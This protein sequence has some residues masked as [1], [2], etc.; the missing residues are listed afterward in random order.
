MMVRNQNILLDLIYKY[1]IDIIGVGPPIQFEN[2]SNYYAT[3]NISDSRYKSLPRCIL[4]A[5]H[6]HDKY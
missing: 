4:Y 5:L 2:N 1:A 6:N 3:K